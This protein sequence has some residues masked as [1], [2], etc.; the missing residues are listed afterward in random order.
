[1]RRQSLA[2]ALALFQNLLE[3]CLDPA[4]YLA[5]LAP[6][7]RGQELAL[8]EEHLHEIAAVEKQF[9]QQQRKVSFN[10]LMHVQTGT[11]RDLPSFIFRL[12]E[13]GFAIVNP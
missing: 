13:W 7:V 3:Y 9:M 4:R 12:R 8:G 6:T 11:A 2:A 5:D 10:I 1:M